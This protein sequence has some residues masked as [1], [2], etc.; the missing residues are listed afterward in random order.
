MPIF[1]YSDMK[2]I[3]STILAL[4]FTFCIATSAA[5]AQDADGRI[6]ISNTS[7]TIIPPRHFEYDP[8]TDRIAHAGSLASIHVSEVKGT[9]YKKITDR[10]TRDYLKS[11]GLDL[12]D[13]EYTKTQNGNDATIFRCK[14]MSH[15]DKG[16]ALE[17][18]RLMFFSGEQNTIWITADYPTCMKKLI[19]ETILN[20]ILSAQQQ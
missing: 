6:R 19:G 13:R 18:E 17:F 9:G 16:N 1:F 2:R 7:I 20:S 11:Q 8:H 3:V 4:A 15:D 5:T 10:I 14:F 12:T